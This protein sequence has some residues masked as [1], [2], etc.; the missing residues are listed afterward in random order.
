MAFMSI[1][2]AWVEAGKA[3]KESLFLYIKNNFD[4]HE[5]R[6]AGV[7]AAVEGAAPLTMTV[8][9]KYW[10]LSTT[11][12]TNVVKALVASDITITAVRLYIN[13][14]GTSGTTEVNLLTNTLAGPS[15]TTIFT[16]RPSVGFGSGDDAVSTNAIVDVANA[17]VDAGDII[18]LDLITSQVEGDGFQV[19]IEYTYR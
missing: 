9:G 17:N 2:S 10:L 16:T 11:E 1:P 19:L 18:R 14:A 15:Y 3:L 7:E 4:D 13:K 8:H 5:A 6:I 12:K